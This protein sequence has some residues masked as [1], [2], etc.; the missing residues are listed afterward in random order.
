[1]R[2]G[3]DWPKIILT[4]RFLHLILRL[5]SGQSLGMSTIEWAALFDWDG[6]IIDS[7]RRHEESW[8]LLALEEKKRLPPDHFKKGFGMK[9]A[10]IIP[11]LLGWTQD[12][13]EIDRISRRKEQLYRGLVDEKGVE[14]LHGVITWLR[15][16]KDAGIPCVIGSSTERQN[17]TTILEKT[18]MEH[19]FQA[20]VS[21]EDVS[22][23][24]PDPEV[25][26][27]A[28]TLAGRSPENCVVFEDAFVGIEAGRAGGMKV[29]GVA[30]THSIDKLTGTD[31]A[32]GRLDELSLETVGSLFL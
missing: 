20:I 9:N 16:L 2:S 7:S 13:S 32:V 8:E 30:T 18:G 3:L 19:Y 28:A 4:R 31:L 10:L 26:L 12:I 21:A 22:K 27:K 14:P 15:L 6:V 5:G 25:F 24:K 23:G 1:V 29:I 17:I 11:G